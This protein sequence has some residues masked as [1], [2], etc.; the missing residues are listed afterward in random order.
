MVPMS[1]GGQD[2]RIPVEQATIDGL[3][4]QIPVSRKESMR[5]V[6]DD[7]EQRAQRAFEAIGSPQLEPLAGWV[8]FSQ[9]LHILDT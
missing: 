2:C 5:W 1:Y 7:F 9:L 6:G 4:D 3:R 8:I